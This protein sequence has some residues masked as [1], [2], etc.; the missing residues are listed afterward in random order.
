MTKARELNS[1]QTEHRKL[2][3]H[4]RCLRPHSATLVQPVSIRAVPHQVLPLAVPPGEPSGATRPLGAPATTDPASR[5]A[6]Q[7]APS[8]LVDRKILSQTLS[9]R[10]SDVGDSD[11]YAPG[12]GLRLATDG[13]EAHV[14]MYQRRP[15]LLHPT[16]PPTRTQP[17]KRRSNALS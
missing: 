2:L 11:G 17:H 10:E 8:Y 4:P 5:A 12:S 6:T 15:S 16:A 14:R 9:C 13:G 7:G 1:L 3:A